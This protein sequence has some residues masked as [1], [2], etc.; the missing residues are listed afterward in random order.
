[1]ALLHL[2]Q[3][4]LCLGQP[5]GHCHGTIHLGGCG[6]CCAGLLTAADLR[7]QRAET[8]V[9]M[10]LEWAHTELFGHGQGLLIGGFGLCDVG[11]VR[12]GMDDAKLVQRTRLVPACLLLLGQVE[13]LAGML[14]GLLI[15]SC[16]PTGLAEPGDPVGLTC[17]PPVLT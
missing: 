5:P 13:C 10:R 12:I 8:E 14:P 6:Q 2:R 4:R 1:M 7:I 9:A 11:G 3:R 15:A 16:Q 17:Q